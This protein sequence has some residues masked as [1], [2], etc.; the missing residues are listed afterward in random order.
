M[1]FF[2]PKPGK[3]FER[4]FPC[5]V[6][7]Y[8]VFEQFNG[9]SLRAYW[10]P[11]KFERVTK[12]IGRV[13]DKPSDFPW[14]GNSAIVMR[15]RAHDILEDIFS[16]NGEIL[17][18]ETDDDV[19]L[20]MFNCQVIDAFDEGRSK[21]DRLDTGK[22]IWIN[23]YEFIESKLLGVDM[24]RIPRRSSSVFVSERFVERYKAAEL[25]GLEFEEVW[26]SDGSAEPS[27]K[28][29]ND[30]EDEDDEHFE[31][32]H[33]YD[34]SPESSKEECEFA[35]NYCKNYIKSYPNEYRAHEDMGY[36]YFV[37]GDY[38]NL[39][40]C[41][42]KLIELMPEQIDTNIYYSLG[43]AYFNKED[44]DR[45][46]E[47]YEKAIE[48]DPSAMAAYYN[49]GNAYFCKNDIDRAIACFGKAIE[50]KPDFPSAYYNMGVAYEEKGDNYNAEK[51]IEKAKKLEYKLE[52]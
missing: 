36:A 7:Y 12:D 14:Y 18:L 23:K 34:L 3:K 33:V 1:K 45:A 20:F 26:D 17:P 10:Q 40:K 22:I 48:M 46:I 28:L 24:F 39:V 13:F 43:T 35:I 41:Y 49:M 19:E 27:P 44:Y 52:E 15:K 42:E 30:N 50:L 5:N 2:K 47:F 21:V 6:K 8:K 11:I 9:S 32:E 4:A 37:M 38:D 25:V 31:L 16:Q 29:I 51:Y